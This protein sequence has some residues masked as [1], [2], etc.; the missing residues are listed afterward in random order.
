MIF[1]LITI[2]VLTVFPGL[3]AAA[4]S[5]EPGPLA[6]VLSGGGAKGMAHIGVL[7]SLD[8]IG[9]RPDLIV[10]T[11]M[12]AIVGGM[13]ASGLSATQIDSISKA[14]PITGIFEAARP[15][16]SAVWGNRLPLVQW[17]QGEEGLVLRAGGAD[18]RQANAILNA[19][20]LAGN[21]RARGDFDLLPIRFRAVAT[22]LKEWQ[23]V[24]IG[25]GDLAQ[26]V[27]ASMAIPVVFPPERIGG[28]ILVD[29][30]LT[31]NIPVGVAR[32]LGAIRLIVS[33]VTDKVA[34]DSIPTDGTLDVVNR[35][36]EVLFEQPLDSLNPGDRLI[37]PN[38]D[39]FRS[40]DF[41]PARLALLVELGRSAADSA[42]QGFCIAGKEAEGRRI[43][44]P[45]PRR[46]GGI[47]LRNAD[48][49][50]LLEQFL[51]I[52]PGL[53]LDSLSLTQGLLELR[54]SDLYRSLW[55]H[56]TGA[57]DSVQFTPIVRRAPRRTAGIGLAYD[58]D[59]GGQVWFGI[60]ERVG[61]ADA[62]G[63]SGLLAL[64]RFRRELEFAGRL[65]TGIS[66]YSIQPTARIGFHNTVI[67]KFP[68]PDVEDTREDVEEVRLFLG[69]ERPLPDNWRFVVGLEP[70]LFQITDQSTQEVFGASIG[71]SKETPSLPRQLLATAE[72]TTDWQR[73]EI[74][75][76]TRFTIGRYSAEPRG[77]VGWGEDLPIH[78][79]FVFGGD[80]GFPGLT[81]QVTRGDRETLLSLQS[82]YR[83]A[84][85]VSARLLLAT[86]RSSN[87][88]ALFDD[89]NWRAGARAGFGVE[90]LLGPILF[91]FGWADGGETATWVRLG[92]W[93]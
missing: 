77:R 5:C 12:G 63:L 43:N 91:E 4:Q 65:T 58:S 6:L 92:R 54:R 38:V 82:S 3:S 88:G 61:P 22:D 49:G 33:D 35:L 84:G 70:S 42:L 37:R 23:P 11:S 48:E 10:G 60:E 79:T 68:I 14:L 78:R 31:A 81:R 64:A 93:F 57:G 56:P 9:I 45:I 72:W 52:T 85:P 53:S 15:E 13:Y 2:G 87:G 32:S 21:L 18:E 83:L 28:R 34:L 41:T 71:I 30:G 19:T 74:E 27:R 75:L 39:G 73:A 69:L 62:V 26:A 50:A 89:D 24:V 76:A 46:H 80:D 90:S 8:S 25:S 67:R 40:L 51:G 20:L 47:R 66:R 44:P 16:A 1:R 17:V 7:K 36:F 55:L 59:L 29:G 86:G